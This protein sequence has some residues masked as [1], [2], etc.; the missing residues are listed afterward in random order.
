MP[1]IWVFRSV[2]SGWRLGSLEAALE[3]WSRRPNPEKSPCR[4][5]FWRRGQGYPEDLQLGDPVVLY[6]CAEGNRPPPGGRGFKA[7]SSVAGALEYGGEEVLLPI[8]ILHRLSL[9]VPLA[10]VKSDPLLREHRFSK[11]AQETRYLFLGED[12]ARLAR[13]LAE[14]VPEAEGVE[15]LKLLG[16]KRT[17]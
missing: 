13:V 15:I 12:A 5:I 16:V 4:R 9:T 10:A 1:K 3:E 14:A 6:E 2:P 17:T 8:R 7:I 11:W